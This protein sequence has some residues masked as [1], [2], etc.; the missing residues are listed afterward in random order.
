MTTSVD[1]L[2]GLIAVK[3]LEIKV[4]KERIAQLQ[5]QVNALAR[6]NNQLYALIEQEQRANHPVGFKNGGQ[7]D[8][9]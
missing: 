1:V 4:L 9:K 7:D 5:S 2:V 8:K 3:E 6:E